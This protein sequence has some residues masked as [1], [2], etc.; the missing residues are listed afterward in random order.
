MINMKRQAKTLK[1]MLLLAVTVVIVCVLSVLGAADAFGI[2]L[3]GL[4]GYFAVT[5]QGEQILAVMNKAIRR[6]TPIVE[7]VPVFRPFLLNAF[8]SIGLPLVDTALI[9]IRAI[10]PNAPPAIIR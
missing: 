5:A 4:V 1:A 8:K 6:S 9:V 10:P 7:R 2:Y 3:C